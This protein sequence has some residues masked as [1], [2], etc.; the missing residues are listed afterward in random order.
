MPGHTITYLGSD[1]LGWGF[2]C[3]CGFKLE[4]IMSKGDRRLEADRHKQGKPSVGFPPQSHEIMYSGSKASQFTWCCRCGV[5]GMKYKEK[6]PRTLAANLHL[7]HEGQ[8]HEWPSW[9]K[10]MAGVYDDEA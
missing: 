10:Q 4:H 1:T 9:Y 3:S 6:G 5:Q 8:P 7:I 2:Q